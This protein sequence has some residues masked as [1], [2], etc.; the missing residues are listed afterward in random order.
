[1]PK[2]NSAKQ[3]SCAYCSSTSGLT[4]EHI[5]PSSIIRLNATKNRAKKFWLSK[6][7][8]EVASDPTV[9]DVCASCNNGVLSQLDAY[10]AD[11]FEKNCL[12]ADNDTAGQK[13]ISYDYHLLKRWS[14][15]VSYNSVRASN[16]F[17][18]PAFPPLLPY[19]LGSDQKLGRSCGLYVQMS[20][21]EEVSEAEQLK[22]FETQVSGFIW[23]PIVNRIGTMRMEFPEI[24]TKW[25]KTISLRSVNI[26]LTFFDPNSRSAAYDKQMDFENYFTKTVPGVKRL[27]PNQDRVLLPRKG[28]GAWESFKDARRYSIS[29]S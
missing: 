10:A 12:T 20:Y 26:Y 24:G 3:R 29:N 7:Q 17:G 1:M 25:F 15:K 14:L 27:S 19:I 13:T 22:Y 4:K 2:L 6:V 16:G 11:F 5:F 28:I 9:K 8:K 21:P 23:E 18:A